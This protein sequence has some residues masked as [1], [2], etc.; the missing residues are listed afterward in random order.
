MATLVDTV[1][2]STANS[3]ATVAECTTYLDERLNAGAWTTAVAA[4]ADDDVRALIQ[5]TRMID[6][7]TFEGQ[8]TN[9]LNGTSTGTTQALKFP[10]YSVDNDAGWVW[11]SDVIP[12]PVKDATCE[13]ALYLLNQG[14]TDPTQPTGL[15]GF[16]SV[17]VGALNV[18]PRRGF[19]ASDIPDYIRKILSPLL[20]GSR[21]T[22]RLYRA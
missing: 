3:Y 8:P 6:L 11:E 20:S 19:S 7:L 13:L 17:Q 9:P 21:N 12:Q 14:T 5:A 18:T 16:E 15:E 2:S 1:G 10:R 22:A 4:A